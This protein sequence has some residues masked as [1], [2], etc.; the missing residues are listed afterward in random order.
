MTILSDPTFAS[1]VFTHGDLNAR[2]ILIHRDP[3]TKLLNL[4]GIVDFEWAGFFSVYHEFANSEEEAF[5]PGKDGLMD[6]MLLDEMEKLGLET[7][8][9]LNS[10]LWKQARDLDTLRTNVAPWWLMEMEVG[11]PRLEGELAN[12]AKVV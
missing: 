11:N 12:A 4:S 7:V 9:T 10:A 1:S 6:R 2:N 5:N 3:S 8:R